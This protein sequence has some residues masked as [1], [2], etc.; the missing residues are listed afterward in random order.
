MEEHNKKLDEMRI[1][2]SDNCKDVINKNINTKEQL[3]NIYEAIFS[4]L[5]ATIPEDYKN[6]LYDILLEDTQNDKNKN[7]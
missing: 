5:F 7:E 2:D 4:S 6:M 3:K 1:T